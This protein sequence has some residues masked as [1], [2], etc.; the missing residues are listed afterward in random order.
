MSEIE[1]MS[2]IFDETEQLQPLFEL[3]ESI[4]NLPDDSLEE[5]VI[6]SLTDMINKAISPAIKSESIAAMLRGFE[7]QNYT[8]ERAK[9]AVDTTKKEFADYIDLLK[10][11]PVK[12]KL[13]NSV[14]NAL[15]EIFD[16]AVEQ[17]HGF[18]VTLPIMLEENAQI[19]TYAHETD[20]AADLYAAESITLPAHSLSNMV[21]TGVHIALPEGWAALVLPR[22]S[23]GLKTGLRLSNSV[24]LIDEEYRGQIGVIYDNISDSD[25]TINAGDRIAQLLVMPSYRFKGNLVTE[26]PESDRGEGGFGSTGK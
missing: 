8:R 12:R 7:E 25:Y 26:L 4:M 18:S 17:Y 3:V 24:G 19:P 10:P 2:S 14:F 11:T 16:S 23:M 21:R 1:K 15:Y 9:F 13:L 20:A 6:E 22:S 5:P